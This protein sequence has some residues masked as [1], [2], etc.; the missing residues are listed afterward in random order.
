MD[1]IMEETRGEFRKL[2]EETQPR[3]QAIEMDPAIKSAPFSTTNSFK[4]TM[5]SPEY[6]E[7]RRERE[8]RQ[9]PNK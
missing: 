1:K 5:S 8:Q 9:R 6:Y 4:N 7:K 2:R 3:F